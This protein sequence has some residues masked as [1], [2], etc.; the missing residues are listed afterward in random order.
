MSISSA[1]R[2]SAL[3]ITLLFLIF[4]TSVGLS[5]VSTSSFDVKLAGASQMKAESRQ[6]AF[7]AIDESVYDATRRTLPAGGDLANM[8]PADTPLTVATEVPGTSVRLVILE[9]TSAGDPQTL[10]ICPRGT[11][12]WEE[13]SVLCANARLTA[14]HQFDA[15][16]NHPRSQTEALAYQRYLNPNQN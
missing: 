11:T 1:Q 10:T 5:L 13:G 12:A 16:N 3:I 2:G 7:G 8:N 6:A 14:S 15:S 4:L 9:D